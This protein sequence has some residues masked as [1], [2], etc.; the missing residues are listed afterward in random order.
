[1]DRRVRPNV[2]H[3][4]VLDWMPMCQSDQPRWMIPD[5]KNANR[6]RKKP[7]IYLMKSKKHL[8]RARLFKRNQNENE[9]ICKK[10]IRFIVIIKSSY[11]RKP[12]VKIDWFFSVSIST[13]SQ[14]SC[15]RRWKNTASF[16]MTV[17][18]IYLLVY[19]YIAV[20]WWNK[21]KEK[22]RKKEDSRPVQTHFFFH[23]FLFHLFE[24]SLALKS[25]HFCEFALAAPNCK[26]R[27]IK[28]KIPLTRQ[29]E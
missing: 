10:S 14:V 23:I 12:P 8:A 21:I 13:R 4:F 18:V 6:K 3:H 24:A 2:V 16:Q 22:F 20:G 1:M 5:P 29:R 27:K 11:S 26:Q 7:I 17:L 15:Y 28:I 19:H 25:T 9:V